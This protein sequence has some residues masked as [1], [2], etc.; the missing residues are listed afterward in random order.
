MPPIP[1]AATV[2]VSYHLFFKVYI[3]TFISNYYLSSS[4]SLLKTLTKPRKPLMALP[5]AGS[6]SFNILTFYLQD[7]YVLYLLRLGVLGLL[8]KAGIKASKRGIQR[9]D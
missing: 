3:V 9:S 7:L 8:E 6:V 5:K 1:Q 4:Y 2:F